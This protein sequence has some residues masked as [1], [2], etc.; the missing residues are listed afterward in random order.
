MGKNSHFS[1]ILFTDISDIQYIKKTSTKIENITQIKITLIYFII[2]NHSWLNRKFEYHGPCW[3]VDFGSLIPI[4]LLEF[5]LGWKF[6]SP[7]LFWYMDLYSRR[8][9][10]KI[11]LLT[12]DAEP[13]QNIP[14]ISGLVIS[15]PS[16]WGFTVNMWN[17]LLWL[18]LN[19]LVDY[20]TVNTLFSAVQ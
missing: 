20:I 6:V 8:Y 10:Y 9:L 7:I 15:W 2:D 14:N 4:K 16:Y 17:F 19:F 12:S 13:L 18:N 3:W 1:D 11:H 5:I